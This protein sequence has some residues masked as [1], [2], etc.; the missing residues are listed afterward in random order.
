MGEAVR[1]AQHREPG[2]GR[3]SASDQA[4]GELYSAERNR[5]VRL[6]YLLTGSQ[7]VAEDLVQDVFIKARPRLADIEKPAAYLRRAVT[8]ASWS[9]HRR[10]QREARHLDHRPAIVAGTYDIEIFDALAR[11]SPRR[12]SVLVLRYYL[13]L[14]EAETAD[15]L[16]WRIGTVKSTTH[17][18]LQDLRRMLEP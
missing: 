6:A 8:N 2:A 5:L 4:F 12:R 3:T 11:L 7:A 15:S 10:R 9:W 16:G 1:H 13:D 18:A 14:S 17:R